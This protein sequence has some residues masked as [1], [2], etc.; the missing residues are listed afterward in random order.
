MIYE[1]RANIG[2][3]DWVMFYSRLIVCQEYL[4][5]VELRYHSANLTLERREKSLACN[6]LLLYYQPVSGN[7][8]LDELRLAQ[9]KPETLNW[10]RTYV[11]PIKK[12]R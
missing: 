11:N 7:E 10:E 12:K 8:V 2:D 3:L 9:I 1:F 5:I 4:N 6:G